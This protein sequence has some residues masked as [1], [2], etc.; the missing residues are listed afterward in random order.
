MSHTDFEW[1]IEFPNL[2]QWSCRMNVTYDIS[3]QNFWSY[4]TPHTDT[5]TDSSLTRLYL[6]IMMSTDADVWIR[7]FDSS[8]EWNHRQLR[9]EKGDFRRQKLIEILSLLDETNFSSKGENSLSEKKIFTNEAKTIPKYQIWADTR[10][11]WMSGMS[12]YDRSIRHTK[13]PWQN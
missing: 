11:K 3:L 8:N 7:M 6:K 12:T 1:H 4:L 5:F 9:G 13:M 10:L 2:N